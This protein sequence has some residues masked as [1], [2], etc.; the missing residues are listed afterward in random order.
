MI[1]PQKTE[2]VAS[3]ASVAPPEISQLPKNYLRISC[4]SE[5]NVFPKA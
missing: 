3:P 2:K 1:D 5:V 4:R